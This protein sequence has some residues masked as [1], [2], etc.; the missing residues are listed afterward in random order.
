MIDEIRQKMQDLADS[1]F[2]D[3]GGMM[4]LFCIVLAVLVVINIAFAIRSIRKLNPSAWEIF[5]D[6]HEIKE[7]EQ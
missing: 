3:N 6:N 4:L 7:D 1:S 5:C 2:V